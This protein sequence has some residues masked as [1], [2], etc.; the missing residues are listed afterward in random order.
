MPGLRSFADVE[1]REVKRAKRPNAQRKTTP[2]ALKRKA[3]ALA[4]AIVR[5][6]GACES[7]RDTHAGPLQWA[8]GFSRTYR[9]VRWDLRNGFCLCAAC[10]Y[11]YTL[12][13]IEWDEWLRYRL[14]F[15]YDDLRRRALAGEKRPMEDVV[16]ELAGM[17]IE[18][19]P[20]DI[21][22]V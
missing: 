14:G 16:S 21:E 8:H 6:R 19:A 9:A 12:R 20:F 15:A 1:G 11:F 13:P 7:G 5:A 18:R 22:Q 4:G 3:D 2:A 17:T 10:H